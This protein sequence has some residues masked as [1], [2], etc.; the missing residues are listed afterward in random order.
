MALSTVQ[1]VFDK[2]PAVFDA[3]AAQGLD[4]VFQ[5]DITGEVISPPAPRALDLYPVTIENDVLK[6]DTSRPARRS[7][8]DPAQVVYAKEA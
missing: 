8:Y 7:G 1:E 6:V 5:F 2:M 3:D 4:A